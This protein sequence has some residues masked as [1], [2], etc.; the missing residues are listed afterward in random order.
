MKA[1]RSVLLAVTIVAVAGSVTFA[2][3]DLLSPELVKAMVQAKKVYLITGHVRYHKTKAFVKTELVDSTPFE[4][5]C[6]KELQKWGRFTLVSDVKD[7]DLIVRAYMTGSSQVVPVMSAQVSG[8]VD[9]GQRFIVL[10]VVQP[11]SKKIL[12]IA[13]K[14]S[15]T[16]WSY[17][18]AVGGLVKKLREYIEE[19]EKSSKVSS[20]VPAASA[21]TVPAAPAEQ[22]VNQSKNIYF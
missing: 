7:A 18:T 10:D 15:G 9:I 11:S 2:E 19:Q 17:N 3:N 6:R 12:W 21:N 8:S 13:S 1:L 4:E 16:S 22:Q 5:P 14:N 20:A